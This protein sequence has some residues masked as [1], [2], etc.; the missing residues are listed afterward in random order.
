M[1]NP[2]RFRL[3]ILLYLTALAFSIFT[4]CARRTESQ[5]RATA[6][7]SSA[8]RDERFS[9]Y[10][11]GSSWLDQT[12]ATRSLASLR[13]K[14]VL[15][16]MVYT[17]CAAVCPLSITE[18]KRIETKHPDVQLVLVSLDPA[19]DTPRRL[20]EYAVERGLTS[21]R[22]T[23]LNGSESDVRDLAATIGVRYRRISGD[24]LAHSNILTLL[25][26]DGRVAR[27]GTGVMDDDALLALA[28]STR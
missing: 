24:D 27:Q 6:D 16:A 22:W 25:D 15:L 21:P 18:M 13:G 10:D 19:H 2:M 3:A 5:S 1:T 12:G 7:A 23:L 14:P 4:G 8:A 9:V 17:H 11:L 26:G 20:A 28:G